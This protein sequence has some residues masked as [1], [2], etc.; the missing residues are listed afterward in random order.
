MRGNLNQGTDRLGGYSLV[1]SFKDSIQIGHHFLWR[2]NE[3]AFLSQSID[4]D[5]TIK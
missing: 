2:T 1:N 3:N 4:N 5:E